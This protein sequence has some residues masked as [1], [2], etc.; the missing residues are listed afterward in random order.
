MKNGYDF[1]IDGMLLPITPPSLDITVGSTNET[2]T[3]INEGEIN[4]LKSP[5][6]IEI[7]FE[8]RFP[9]RDYPYAKQVKSFQDYYDK[10]K[11]LK[12][13]KKFFQFVVVRETVGGV[14]TWDTN[15]TVALE[16]FSIKEDA[17]D[18]DDV[19]INFTLKQYKPYGVKT[20]EIKNNKVQ[21]SNSNSNKN[22]S[23]RTEKPVE[24]TTYT[25]K[26]G[27][28]LYLIAKKHYGDGSKWTTIY[29][30][31]KTAIEE[32]AK[33]HGKSSSSN[34]HWIWAG[35]VLNLPT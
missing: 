8:A 21:V 13:K 1:F 28:N 2:L 19:L 34:G 29:N 35:L 16:D 27:D 3:L 20:V 30:A 18:G 10:I 32:D 6:L 25:V 26:Q 4:V 31:N 11:E 22:N 17:E 9:M 5:S 23:E 14:P 12:S 33:K 24:Q 15:L 7:S